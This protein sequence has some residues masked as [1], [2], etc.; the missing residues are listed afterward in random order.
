[1]NEK[2]CDYNFQVLCI[3]NFY[4]VEELN[5]T[6]EGTKSTVLKKRMNELNEERKELII[7]KMRWIR[8][9]ELRAEGVRLIG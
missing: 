1:M 5:V 3:I 2:T 9:N 6:T 8:I 7:E 4:L